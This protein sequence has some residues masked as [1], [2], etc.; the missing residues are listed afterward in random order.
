[1][2]LQKGCSTFALGKIKINII[3]KNTLHFLLWLLMV[4]C[5][6][7]SSGGEDG[8]IPTPTPKP[9]SNKIEISGSNPV[10]EQKAG[11]ATI[12]F[13]TNAAWTASVGTSTSWLSVSPASGAAG[14][15]TLTVTAQENDTYDERNA[16]V[17]IKA[18]SVSKNITVT[19]KQKDALIV[20]SNKVEIGA[21]D[22][23]FFIEVKANVKF[24]YEIE[25]AAQSWITSDGS[26]AL[27]TS[28][29]KFKALENE[30][31]Y[32]RE[33][34]IIIHSGE[35]SET[36]TIYQ[37]GSKPTIVLTQNEYTVASE[38]ETIKVE[39]K[40]NVDYEIQL[41]GVDWIQENSSR[42]MSS[43]THYFEIAPNE[44]YDSRSAEILFIN[45]ENGLSEK[46]TVSQAQKNAIIIAKNEYTVEVTGGS[47]EIVVMTN[48]DLQVKTSVDW[49]ILT[50]T[51]TLSNK[52]LKFT[53]KENTEKKERSGKIT[54]SSGFINQVIT[55]KQSAENNTGGSID[56][57]PEHEW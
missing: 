33:G 16:T 11:T 32:K 30:N 37:E 9:E 6:S 14:T 3:M 48:V 13:T 54:V 55:I 56:G 49:I 43:A 53:I 19:Q 21:E 45:K 28:V 44:E 8:P 39:L 27:T 24:E 29:L 41:P 50:E 12:T 18:G 4:C 7:C 5:W 31:T 57:M 25:E 22:G 34:K 26:R 20:T 38:G 17:T 15:H 35:F 10:V 23:E 1:M 51:R 52:T 36:V 47:L 42:A 40:S 2:E 46:V